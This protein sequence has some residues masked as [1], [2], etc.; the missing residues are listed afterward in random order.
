MIFQWDWIQRK[1][2]WI[3]HVELEKLKVKSSNSIEEGTPFDVYWYSGM[4][5][6]NSN[7]SKWSMRIQLDWMESH[8]VSMYSQLI[9]KG[10]H[11]IQLKRELHSILNGMPLLN[12]NE[13]QWS[14]IFQWDWME[15]HYISNVYPINLCQLTDTLNWIPKQPP[16]KREIHPI[17]LKRELHS[18]SIETTVSMY[19][20]WNPTD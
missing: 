1:I 12:S 2:E 6:I 3:G 10:N 13:S 19:I 11:S 14:M 8:H 15:S 7:E 4:S 20:E 5:L 9:L 16:N 18:M 17:Q